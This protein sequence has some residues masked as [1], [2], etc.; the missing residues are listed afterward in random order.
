MATRV[1]LH[2]A[3]EDP[4]MGEVDQLP[5][6]TDTFIKLSNLRRVDGKDVGFLAEGVDTVIYAWHRVTFVEIL[7][8]ESDR[9]QVV[10]FFRT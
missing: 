7:A 8:S 4:V 2:I 6:P 3:G 9:G 5:Q 10:G 1:I